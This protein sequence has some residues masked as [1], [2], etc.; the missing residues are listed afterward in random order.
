MGCGK[1][2]LAFKEQMMCLNQLWTT[3]TEAEQVVALYSLIKKLN[4]IPCKFLQNLMLTTFINDSAELQI[5][6]QRAN[7]PGKYVIF[8]S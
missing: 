4:P 7:D 1:T 5:S 8:N 6:E 2:N 3:W